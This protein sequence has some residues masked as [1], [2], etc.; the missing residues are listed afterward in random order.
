VN[1]YSTTSANPSSRLDYT[2]PGLLLYSNIK[3]S[4]VFRADKLT[5]LPAG[6]NSTDGQVAS[7][8]YPVLMVFNNPYDQPFKLLSITRTNPTV[9]M[10]WESVFGQSYRVESSTNLTTWATLAGNLVATGTNF[11]YRTNLD[12]APRFFRVLRGW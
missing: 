9:I 10:R 5:P 4:Q 2:F 12:D 6:L 11:I 7:D 1:T 8:H 3:T